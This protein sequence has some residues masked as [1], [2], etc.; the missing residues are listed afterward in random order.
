MEAKEAGIESTVCISN[1]L[2]KR[3]ISK[4]KVEFLKEAIQGKFYLFQRTKAEADQISK[5]PILETYF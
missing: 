1:S 2:L 5:S 4:K 3:S